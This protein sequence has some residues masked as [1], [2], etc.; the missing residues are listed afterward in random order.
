MSDA[1]TRRRIRARNSTHDPDVVG[2]VLDEPVQTGASIRFDPP[3]EAPLARALFAIPGLCRVEA[4]GNT[5]WVKKQ[6]RADWT[7]LKPAAAAAIRQTL[8]ETDAPLG[9]NEDSAQETDPDAELLLAVVGLLD[10]Q[11]NP[12]VAAHGGKISA[13]RVENGTLYLRMSGGCQGCAA[14]SVTLRNGVERMLRAALPHIRE[15]VDVT[16]H[17]EGDNP[18]YARDNKPSPLWNR[19]V[20]EDVIGWDKGQVVIDP[21]YLA[22]KLG[23][24]PDALRTG[25]RLGDVIGITQVGQDKDIGKTRVIMRSSTRAWAA[26]IFADGTAREIPPPREASAALG[27]EREL[28]MRVR[29]HLSGLAPD[30]VPITYGTLARALG[31]WAP[32]SV[33][34]VTRALEATMREDAAAGHPFI[35]ARVVSRGRNKLPA[36][37]FFKLAQN[38]K[39]LKRDSE[40]DRAFHNRELSELHLALFENDNLLINKKSQPI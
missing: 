29:A 11:V 28:A 9:M 4:N 6:A 38:L 26:E 2:F 14:S 25:L 36:A 5:I 24:T 37:E 13:D 20:P 15:I 21:E 17:A 1:P 30:Q 35:A 18:Y 19:I 7:V 16:N 27:R 33:A 12:S 10:R 39:R 22:P 40:G 31:L 32:G 3:G 23:L 8:D 34:R